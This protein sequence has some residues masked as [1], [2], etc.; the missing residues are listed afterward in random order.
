MAENITIIRLE[1]SD[2]KVSSS[3]KT[4]SSTPGSLTAGAIGGIAIGNLNNVEK[5]KFEDEDE[6]KITHKKRYPTRLARKQALNVAR[7]IRTEAWEHLSPS[8]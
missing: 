8:N 3:T 4:S 6:I 2:E 1:L 5:L 7:S